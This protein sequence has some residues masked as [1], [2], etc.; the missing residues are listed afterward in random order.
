MNRNPANS[1]LTGADFDRALG[2]GSD[3]ILPSSGFAEAVMTAVHRE[4]TAPA[5]LAFPWKRALPGLI[6]AAAVVITAVA[7]AFVWFLRTLRASSVQFST[8]LPDWPARFAPFAH[9]A[10]DA[11]WVAVS[12][13]ICA[14]CLLFCRRLISSH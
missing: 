7:A 10:V 4:A 12:V 2:T 3:S 1:Q 11:L 9:H 6:V 5:P 14:A 13:M 8:P